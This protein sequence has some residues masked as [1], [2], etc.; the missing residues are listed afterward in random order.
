M[1]AELRVTWKVEVEYA[2]MDAQ[3]EGEQE[4]RFDSFCAWLARRSLATTTTATTVQ[5]DIG[6]L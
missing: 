3:D 2:R 5:E 4:V 1:V 6:K